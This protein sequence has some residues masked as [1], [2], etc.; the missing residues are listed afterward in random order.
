MQ[1]DGGLEVFQLLTK[2]VCEPG[3]AAAVHSQSVILFFN[4]AC[5]DQINLGIALHWYSFRLYDFW[6]GIFALFR[7]L[8]VAERFDN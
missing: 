5:A 6:R 7:K 1:R 4:I 3:E 8:R 2:S